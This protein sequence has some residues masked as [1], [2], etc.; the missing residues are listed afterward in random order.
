[1]EV[2]VE[3]GNPRNPNQVMGRTRQGRQVF[4]DGDLEQLRGEFVNVHI[5]EARTWSLMGELA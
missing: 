5:T 3:D 1:V 2:L 4:F